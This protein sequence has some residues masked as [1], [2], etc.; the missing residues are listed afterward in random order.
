MPSQETGNLPENTPASSA[1]LNKWVVVFLIQELRR[2]LCLLQGLV[3]CSQSSWNILIWVLFL[4]SRRSSTLCLPSVALSA[5]LTFQVNLL[6]HLCGYVPG[7]TKWQITA[8]TI[9]A[10]FKTSQLSLPL[11]A[12]VHLG[13]RADEITS[14]MDL[15]G[16]WK[17]GGVAMTGWPRPW[18]VLLFHFSFLYHELFSTYLMCVYV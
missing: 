14:R 15:G 18:A 13:A 16:R 1:Y 8:A 7:N 2:G 10:H 6:T 4:N 3:P 5:I 9:I 12:D 11:S 17:R